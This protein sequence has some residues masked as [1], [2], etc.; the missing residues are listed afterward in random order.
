MKILLFGAGGQLGKDIQR[1]FS[2]SDH[3]IP[4]AQS[5]CDIRFFE[6]VKSV[7]DNNKPDIVINSA[8]MTDVP[9]CETQELAAFEVNA[10]AC[11]HLSLASKASGCSLLQISTDYVFDGNSKTPYTEDDITNPVNVYGV[12][13][14]SGEYFVKAYH[15]RFWI[16]RTCGL[17]GIHPNKGKKTNF[18]E[19]MLKL[20]REKDVVRVV[21]DEILTPTFTLDL[22]RQIKKLVSTNHY[23][24]FHATNHGACSWYEFT[25]KIFELQSISTKLEPTTVKAFGSTVRRPAYSVLENKSL[26]EL[27]IDTMSAWQNALAEYFEDRKNLKN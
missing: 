19:T 21:E 8:A 27:H 16:V 2:G 1:I 10:L 4:I 14:L 11:K 18:V 17:Y 22:A 26:K 13:K 12:S 23:G 25:R 3:V 9:G 20:A 15:D 24:V 6:P 5:E 7:I